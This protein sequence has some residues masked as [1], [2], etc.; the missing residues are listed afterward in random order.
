[1]GT[2]IGSIAMLFKL[3]NVPFFAC[4]LLAIF[5][6]GFGFDLI[7]EL[8]SRFYNGRFRLT[9]VGLTGTYT[10]R[11]LFAVIITYVVRYHYWTENGMFK[12]IDYIF[13]SGTVSAILGSIAFPASSLF[14]NRI[15]SFSQLKVRPKFTTTTILTAGLGMWILQIVL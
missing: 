3:V 15:L 1:M 2:A 10:S 8:E 6:L 13:L 4:H 5:L 14:A 9:I 12:L 11:A 7:C